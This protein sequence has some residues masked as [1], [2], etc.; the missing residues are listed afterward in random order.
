MTD[1]GAVRLVH[2]D[3]P[4]S[5]NA[6]STQ[7]MDE[8]CD[9]MLESAE[10]SAVTVLVLTGAGRAFTAGADLAEMGGGSD[11]QAR[12]GFAGLLEAIIEFPKPFI[13][14]VNGVGAGIGAT[15]CGLADLVYMADDARIKAPFST[16]GLTAEAGS[17]YTFPQLMGRQRAAWFLWSSEWM[18]GAECVAAG[19][20]L[21][22][23]PGAELLPHV[24]SK[25]EQLAALP[26]ASL[27]KTK[28]LMIEP[29]KAQLRA[30]FAAEN[31]GLAELVGGPANKQALAAFVDKRDPDFSSL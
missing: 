10:A 24:L 31:R 26:L 6:F 25:A 22:S 17:T 1:H 21:E 23:L 27:M 2:L 28:A 16:L 3:R 13:I 8:L 7:L 9:V 11:Y 20:A 19:L 15:I 14:A 29:H 12:H 4:D 18:D 30:S 5:L